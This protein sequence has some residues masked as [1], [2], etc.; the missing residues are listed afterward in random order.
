VI[1]ATD[2]LDSMTDWIGGPK[3]SKLANLSISNVFRN[4]MAGR[5]AF[6]VKEGHLYFYRSDLARFDGAPRG[7]PSHEASDERSFAAKDRPKIMKIRTEIE[8]KYEDVIYRA[9]ENGDNLSLEITV[10]RNGNWAVLPLR[11]V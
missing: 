1:K 5:I 7:R 9:V 3:A 8:Q 6:R 11:T 4:A 2:N 10:Y